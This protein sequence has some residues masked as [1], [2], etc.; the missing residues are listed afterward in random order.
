M[1]KPDPYGDWVLF[2]TQ[3]GDAASRLQDTNPN[4]FYRP[5]LVQVSGAQVDW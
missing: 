2:P 4:V 1:E 3:K 5:L